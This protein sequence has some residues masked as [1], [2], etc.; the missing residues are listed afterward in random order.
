MTWFCERPRDF[1]MILYVYKPKLCGNKG[2]SSYFS[3]QFF[4]L[5]KQKKS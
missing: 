2:K 3:E 4:N 5:R 1:L